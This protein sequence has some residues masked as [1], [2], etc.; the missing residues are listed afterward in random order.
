MGEQEKNI[1]EERGEIGN[2]NS[3]MMSDDVSALIVR[4]RE[5]RKAK[6]VEWRAEESKRWTWSREV[7][8]R[9]PLPEDLFR[10]AAAR[11][12]GAPAVAEAAQQADRDATA[13]SI[14]PA[15]ELRNA[16]AL[17]MSAADLERFGSEGGPLLKAGLEQLEREGIIN[18]EREEAMPADGGE[19]ETK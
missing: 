1:P 8:A 12:L 19:D 3:E 18:I 15:G 2:G 13:E 7:A 11:A 10:G 4:R 9:E 17:P 5:E 16:G 6:Q 14:Q